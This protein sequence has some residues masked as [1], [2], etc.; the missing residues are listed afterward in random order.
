MNKLICQDFTNVL[1]MFERFNA[2]LWSNASYSSTAS[3]INVLFMK[4]LVAFLKD[5]WCVNYWAGGITRLWK[6]R[7]LATTTKAIT[8]KSAEWLATWRCTCTKMSMIKDENFLLFYVRFLTKRTKTIPQFW[9]S[10]FAIVPYSSHVMLRMMNKCCRHPWWFTFE[11]GT[12]ATS[13]IVSRHVALILGGT[14]QSNHDQSMLQTFTNS[15][16]RNVQ[17]LTWNQACSNEEPFSKW[18]APVYVKKTME[19][20]LHWAIS[21]NSGPNTNCFA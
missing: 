7:W 12:S 1:G 5:V 4:A 11:P 13:K 8:R 14:I 18:W 10:C 21:F 2:C 6:H 3:F 17:G 19:N 20:F 16:G 15:L 9:V